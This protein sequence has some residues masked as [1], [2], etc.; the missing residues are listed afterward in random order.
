MGVSQNTLDDLLDKKVITESNL[1]YSSPIVLFKR[2]MRDEYR[3]CIDYRHLN[4]LTVKDRYPIPRID[5]HFD[6][7]RDKV[8]YTTLDLK[9]GFHHVNVNEESVPYTSLLPR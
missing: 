4:K 1:P 7:S 9:N 8:Y 5:D 3:L 6:A 2:E